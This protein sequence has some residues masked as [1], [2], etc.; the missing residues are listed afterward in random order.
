MPWFVCG[1]HSPELGQAV[2]FSTLFTQ[3]IEDFLTLK[4]N[5]MAKAKDKIGTLLQQLKRTDLRTTKSCNKSRKFQAHQQGVVHCQ[6]K[7]GQNAEHNSRTS[8]S[9]RSRQQQEIHSSWVTKQKPQIV[10][11]L[12]LDGIQTN[13]T[14]SKLSAKWLKKEIFWPW[15]R[16][17]TPAGR[18]PTLSMSKSN[19]NIRLLSL[20]T[21]GQY[22][23]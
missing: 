7:W 23:K 10:W 9:N 20:I 6:S 11:I 2:V 14:L 18:P 12:C 15:T 1:I 3:K 8:P 16:A 4:K 5:R 19:P 22:S 21:R 13:A 17:S